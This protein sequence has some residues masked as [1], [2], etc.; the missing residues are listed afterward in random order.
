MKFIPKWVLVAAEYNEQSLDQKAA[1]GWVQ[2]SLSF[3]V[4]DIKTF[5]NSQDQ[6]LGKQKHLF[7]CKKLRLCKWLKYLSGYLIWWR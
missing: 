6:V 2:L 1:R 7:S 4:L 3:H 5:A